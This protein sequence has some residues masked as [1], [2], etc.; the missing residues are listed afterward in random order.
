MNMEVFDVSRASIS[1]YWSISSAIASGVENT[2]DHNRLSSS[3]CPPISE[4]TPFPV[5]WETMQKTVLITSNGYSGP[6]IWVVGALFY[7]H[8]Y[9]TTLKGEGAMEGLYYGFPRRLPLPWWIA[10]HPLPPTGR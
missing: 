9:W 8:E 5:L 3:T 6:R 2:A 10:P 4:S 7:F 1:R